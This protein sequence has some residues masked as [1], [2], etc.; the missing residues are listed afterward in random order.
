MAEAETD[1]TDPGAARERLTRFAAGERMQDVW[2]GSYV[3]DLI[4]EDVRAVMAEAAPAEPGE[5]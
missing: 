1:D 5:G 4:R 3:P 2:Q